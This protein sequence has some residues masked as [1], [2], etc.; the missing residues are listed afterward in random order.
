MCRGD[1][2]HVTKEQR[3]WQRGRERHSCGHIPVEYKKV[4]CLNGTARDGLGGRVRRGSHQVVTPVVP[5]IR[6]ARR[7][8][9]RRVGI[10]WASSAGASARHCRV[11][12][13]IAADARRAISRARSPPCGFTGDTG[14]ARARRGGARGGRV[15][16][17]GARG[18]DGAAGGRHVGAGGARGA[19]VEARSGRDVTSCAGGADAVRARLACL[20]VGARGGP[21]GV[22]RV[23]ESRWLL[24]SGAGQTVCSVFWVYGWYVLTG[25]KTR[26]PE[27]GASRQ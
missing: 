14:S 5:H 20:A 10:G 25:Q 16:A 26:L 23:R 19:G 1:G 6:H 27:N 13:G 15:V 7:G 21:E 11:E 8:P 3:D 24:V 4:P 12:V 17:R 18:A 22:R 2:S 9:P